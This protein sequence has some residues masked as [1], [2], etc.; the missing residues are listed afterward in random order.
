[1]NASFF[2]RREGRA[3]HEKFIPVALAYVWV[4]THLSSIVSHRIEA[5]AKTSRARR[6]L[7]E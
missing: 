2:L 1:M 5:G 4:F 3:A 6:S 7:K